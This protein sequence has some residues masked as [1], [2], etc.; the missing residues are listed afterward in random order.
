MIDVDWARFIPGC[1]VVFSTMTIPD[2]RADIDDE[3][4]GIVLRGDFKLNVSWNP[5][6]KLYVLRVYRGSMRH[7]P[8]AESTHSSPMEVIAAAANWSLFAESASD[9]PISSIPS[10]SPSN[11]VSLKGQQEGHDLELAVA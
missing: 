4:A 11:E 8:I 2:D 10:M 5:K 6:K 3:V 7:L 1:T 9:S